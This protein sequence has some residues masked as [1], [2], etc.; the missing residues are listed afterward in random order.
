LLGILGNLPGGNKKKQAVIAGTQSIIVYGSP[1]SKTGV[2]TES[3]YI[4]PP[5]NWLILP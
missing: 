2:V 4:I 1:K 5:F 3:I